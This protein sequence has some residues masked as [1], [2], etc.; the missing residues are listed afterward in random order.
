MMLGAHL[1]SAVG[2]LQ[3]ATYR[4]AAE[5]S[6]AGLAS[7]SAAVSYVI[8]CITGGYPAHRRGSLF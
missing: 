3:G 7:Y 4:R 6:L 2:L 1:G 8:M 5:S